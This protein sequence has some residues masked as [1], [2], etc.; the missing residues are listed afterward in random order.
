MSSNFEPGFI[1]RERPTRG[2]QHGCE[3]RRILRDRDTAN[4]PLTG[5]LEF[6]NR[7]SS[8]NRRKPSGRQDGQKQVVQSDLDAWEAD[9]PARVGKR[10]LQEE[11]T[12]Y[13]V[14]VPSIDVPV[15]MSRSLRLALPSREAT[16]G[17]FRVPGSA[18]VSR[19][20]DR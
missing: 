2:R 1:A 17:T 13:Q 8:A 15:L 10:R 12:T 18:E 5:L 16:R 4:L 9:N 11:L 20:M 14:V 7:N 6:E 3:S 19:T